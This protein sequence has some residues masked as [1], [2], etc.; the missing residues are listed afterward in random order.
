MEGNQPYAWQINN[1]KFTALDQIELL[2][3]GYENH[4]YG[5]KFVRVRLDK[6]LK[7]FYKCQNQPEHCGYQLHEMHSLLSLLSLLTAVAAVPCPLPGQILP[8]PGNLLA[9]PTFQSPFK[10]LTALLDSAVAGKI[11]AGIPGNETSFSI[12]VTDAQRELWSYHHTATETKN[13]TSK[14]G[15]DSQYRIASISKA[16]TD[17]LMIK[18]GA[19]LDDKI[20]KYLPGLM[21]G[22]KLFAWDQVTLRDLGAQLSGIGLLYGFTDNFTA[23]GDFVKLGFPPAPKSDYPIC[24]APGVGPSCT[25]ALFVKGISNEV[26]LFPPHSRAAYSNVA[27]TLLAFAASNITGLS[28]EASV[29]KYITEPLWMNNTS[30]LPQSESNMVIPPTVN[31][32][33]NADFG[34]NNAGGGAFSTVSDLT[35]LAQ[36]ILKDGSSPFLSSTEIQTWLKPLSF[37]SDLYSAI[38]FPWEIVRS[39]NLSTRGDIVDIYAKDGGVPGYS[40]RFALIPDY[41]IGFIVLVA[42]RQS[43]PAMG[44][45]AEAVLAAAFPAVEAAGY[46]EIIQYG[47]TGRFQAGNSSYVELTTD[48]GPGILVKS[49]HSNG[50]DTMTEV[51][52][53]SGG[54]IKSWRMYFTGVTRGEDE[55]WRVQFETSELSL[56]TSLG[57][58]K[59]W[60]EICL[61]WAG[62][63]RVWYAGKGV[64]R[65]IVRKRHGLVWAI[66]SP[67]FRGVF[68]KVN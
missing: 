41:G 10:N 43:S 35:K 2:T 17:L 25:E 30:F 57:S 26:P 9:S 50:V 29:A 56:P 55:D 18:V 6:R 14:V 7:L 27:F 45:I 61:G 16:I 22:N 59:V 64:D 19:N 31:E 68:T 51:N 24:D 63:D 15:P 23:Q 32:I 5:L 33:W 52:K 13:G 62:V 28:Y 66:E 12:I 44:T 54:T 36:T 1:V 49:F 39:P 37:N 67:A 46:E 60:D 65:V 47:Y 34:I 20:T 58:K 3:L 38:G 8:A 21:S 48:D 4:Q 40:S 11:D 53:L 42:G